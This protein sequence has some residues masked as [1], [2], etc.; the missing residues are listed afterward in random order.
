[1]KNFRA[2]I[3]VFSILI[4]T[5]AIG[6]LPDWGA[7]AGMDTLA[8]EKQYEHKKYLNLP[9][10]KLNID[11]KK[12]RTGQIYYADGTISNHVLQNKVPAGI[13][14]QLRNNNRF[15][16]LGLSESKGTMWSMEYYDLPC[17]ENIYW[18][19]ANDNAEAKIDDRG[20]ENTQ[21]ILDSGK[22]RKAIYPAASY[23]RRYAAEEKISGDWYLPAIGELRE[24]LGS[25]LYPVNQ[26]LSRLGLD[27]IKN[28]GDLY[29]SS[30]EY[31]DVSSWAFRPSDGS[32]DVYSKVSYLY[33]RC[34]V[35]I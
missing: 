35:E 15:V 14:I 22:F 30:T 9:E 8:W 33:V 3:S 20:R 5:L 4:L 29:W 24:I 31:Y 10:T 6:M 34:V 25:N 11:H 26:T 7:L 12:L 23:C 17:E 21:C 19:S 32:L 28:S 1:M 16:V 2:D 18:N 13:V 27:K